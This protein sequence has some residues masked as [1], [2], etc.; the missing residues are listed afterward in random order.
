MAD[1]MVTELTERKHVGVKVGISN[2]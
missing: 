2:A 1:F